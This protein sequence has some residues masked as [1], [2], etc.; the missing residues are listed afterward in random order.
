MSTPYV[1]HRADLADCKVRPR[2][3][4]TSP[5]GASERVTMAAAKRRAWQSQPIEARLWGR[6]RP[7]PRTGCLIFRGALSD[8]YGYVSYQGV[9]WR[10]HRL[11]YTLRV[12]PIPPGAMILHRCVG[13][14][15]CISEDCLRPGL[16]KDNTSDAIAQGRLA[17]GRKCHSAKL[18]PALVRAIRRRAPRSTRVELAGR[19]GVSPSTISAVAL[20]QSWA[21]VDRE[22]AA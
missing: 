13:R 17:R 9:R 11:A 6:A 19:F 4:P 10:A 7:D 1:D 8:G 15:A 5:A 16:A 22:A 3:Q 20:G 12:G 18:T 2:R 14:R 21:W